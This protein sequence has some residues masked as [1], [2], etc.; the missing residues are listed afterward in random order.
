M[1]STSSTSASA[2]YGPRCCTVSSP[3][4]SIILFYTVVVHC[5]PQSKEFDMLSADFN[6]TLLILIIATLFFAMVVCR[7]IV[8]RKTLMAYWK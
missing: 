4:N 3:P 5:Y 2:R 8:N 7:S 6:Y 1:A